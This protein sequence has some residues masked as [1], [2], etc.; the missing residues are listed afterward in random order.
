M[1]DMMEIMQAPEKA[2][3]KMIKDGKM[4]AHKIHHQYVFNKQEIKEWI[5]KNGIKINKRFLELKLGNIP[6]SITRLVEKG[7]I[8]QKVK[9]NN[10]SAAISY[11]VSLMTPPAGLTQEKILTSLIE[12]EEMMHTAVGCGIAIPHPRNPVVT[13]VENESVTACL[14]DKSVPFSAMDGEPVHTMFIVLSANPNRHLEI[15]SKLLYLCQQQD[16]TAMLKAGGPPKD[17]ISYIEKAEAEMEAKR[18]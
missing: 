9:G 1:K 5:I 13:D 4:P 16:F 15:L 14:L 6:V 2:V 10:P 7:G 17:I 12:R 18:K 11:A 8:L 3:Q